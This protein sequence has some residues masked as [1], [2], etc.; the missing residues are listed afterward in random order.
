MDLDRHHMGLAIRQ[1]LEIRQ[2]ARGDAV[3]DQAGDPL[4]QGERVGNPTY[5]P[6]PILDSDEDNAAR[7]VGEGD[8]SS[9]QSLGRRQ[10]ALELEG[11]AFGVAQCVEEVHD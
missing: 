7:G 2:Q 1:N 11:L 4:F 5:V 3:R 8:H 9:Q 6:S 10:V